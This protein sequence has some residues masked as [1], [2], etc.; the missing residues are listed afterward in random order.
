MQ[1]LP[2]PG[3]EPMSPA[4]AAR[5]LYTR[6]KEKS[7]VP[8]WALGSSENSPCS[9]TASLTVP[10]TLD[11]VTSWRAFLIKIT[12]DPGEESASLKSEVRL[13]RWLSGKRIRLPMHELWEMQFP[14]LG[15]EDSPGE[16]IATHSS[17]LAWRIPG[18]KEPGML[19]S[20]GSQRVRRD[21]AGAGEWGL[22]FLRCY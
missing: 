12:A 10:L 9:D 14:S 18:T 2:W 11:Y 3:I 16:E 1:D 19:Q 6:P 7:P 15:Q 20:M 13:P 22:A 8:F 5:F 21:W 4:L 17:I